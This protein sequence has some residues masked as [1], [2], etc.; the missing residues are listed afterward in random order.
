MTTVHGVLSAALLAGTLWMAGPVRRVLA[1]GAAR[2]LG[3]LSY[4]LYLWQQPL[5]V[6]REPSW[7]WARELPWALGLTLALGAL[8]Y[9]LVERPVL[10]WRDRVLSPPP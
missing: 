2:W 8:S 5:L 9:F 3:A 10:R 1:S 4:S 6:T 7:G